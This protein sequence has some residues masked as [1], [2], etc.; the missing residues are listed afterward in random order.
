MVSFS[1]KR[2]TSGKRYSFD[3]S[4]TD[5]EEKDAF[6]QRLKNIRKLL[7]PTG[8]PLLEN[9]NLI[10]A[11]LDLA[12]DGSHPTPDPHVLMLGQLL[13][14]LCTIVVSL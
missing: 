9:Q 2:K 12:E 10:Y 7:T 3:L 11:L 1:M 8:A 5:Q 13:D 14:L 4:F 6:L